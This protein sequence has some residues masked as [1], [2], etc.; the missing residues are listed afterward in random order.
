MRPICWRCFSARMMQPSSAHFGSSRSKVVHKGEES[1]VPTKVPHALELGQRL[2][3]G[4]KLR[5]VSLPDLL[6]VLA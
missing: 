4:A 1:L 5:N 2:G 3:I 6:V